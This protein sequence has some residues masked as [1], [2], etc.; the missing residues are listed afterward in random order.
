MGNEGGTTM[1]GLTLE[2]L[3]C[4]VDTL[5]SSIE[6][7]SWN[8]LSLEDYSD[9]ELMTYYALRASA[10]SKLQTILKGE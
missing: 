6:T 9:T 4:I 5:E 1:T 10:L 3:A 8:S 2:E 7:S